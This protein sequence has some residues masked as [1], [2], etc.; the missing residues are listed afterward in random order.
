LD[1]NFADRIVLVTVAAALNC[2]GC[3]AGSVTTMD[4]AAAAAAVSR[5]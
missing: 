2:F 5:Q 4:G 3:V 1:L